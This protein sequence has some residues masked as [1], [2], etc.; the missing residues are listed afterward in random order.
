MNIITNILKTTLGLYLFCGIN[1]VSAEVIEA[2]GEGTVSIVIQPTGS[3]SY[4]GGNVVVDESDTGS[5]IFNWESNSDDYATFAVSANALTNA[6]GDTIALS[7]THDA[8]LTNDGGGVGTTTANYTVGIA[9]SS[10][11]LGSYTGSLVATI[12]HNL[13]D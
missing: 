11:D 8:Q 1:F 7:V 10:D 13:Q 6:V 9:T 3:I 12:T 2:E 4:I 5:I